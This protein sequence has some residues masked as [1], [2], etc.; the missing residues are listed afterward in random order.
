MSLQRG[1]WH[2][3]LCNTWHALLVFGIPLLVF[4]SGVQWACRVGHG[5]LTCV[6]PDMLSLYL[7]VGSNE[8]A[9]WVMAYMWPA[10]AKL[11]AICAADII[12]KVVIRFIS[13]KSNL[14]NGTILLIK[15]CQFICISSDAGLVLLSNEHTVWIIRRFKPDWITTCWAVTFFWNDYQHS[16]FIK[17]YNSTWWRSNIF[18]LTNI[19]LLCAHIGCKL[20]LMVT[21]EVRIYFFHKKCRS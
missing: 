2:T 16:I 1:S 20:F 18:I 3:Y 12:T 4:G 15:P 19:F 8:L 21:A 9:A 6:T 7:A 14:K 13:V 17:F 5:T 11:F 10:S